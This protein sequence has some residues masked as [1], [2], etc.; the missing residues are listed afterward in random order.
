[1]VEIF[2]TDPPFALFEGTGTYHASVYQDGRPYPQRR[3]WWFST[4]NAFEVY[5]SLGDAYRAVFAHEFFH[6]AQQNVVLSA[7]CTANRW[8]NL[9]IEAQGKFVP[10]VQ[11]P[12]MEL[13]PNHNDPV[14]SEY[15]GAANRFLALRLNS[16]YRDLEADGTNQYDL[17][18]YWRFLYE[19]SNDMGIIRAALEEMACHSDPDIVRGIK[20]VMDRAFQ[21]SGGP[22]RT[23]EESLVAFARANYALRLENGRCA[24]PNLA[25]CD[26]FYYDPKG[27][28]V[29][30]PL[31]AELVYDGTPLTYSGAI[32][33]SFG[34]DFIEVQLDPA[35]HNQP[36]TVKIQGEGAVARYNIQIWQLGSGATRPWAVKPQ[37]QSV[38]QEGDGAHVYTIPRLDTTGY[39][40]LALI[41]TRLDADE[42][43]DPVGSYRITVE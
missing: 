13:M 17:A 32:P 31:E 2:I 3:L 19:Q 39:Q 24:A 14:E 35:V 38:P 22:F 26:G 29:D 37:P 6:L 12:E 40:R 21:R 28:Y 16:S 25:E 7:G 5:D 18:L 10:S 33:S 8:R 15:A 30:P 41:I 42:T 20:P 36:L 27:M 11:H 34:M 1:M 43:A 4:N 23:F 9:F